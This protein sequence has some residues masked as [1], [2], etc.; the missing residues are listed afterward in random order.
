MMMPQ[1]FLINTYRKMFIKGPNYLESLLASR[2]LWP[3]IS[4]SFTLL[5]LELKYFYGN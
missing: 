4:F 3:D 2:L 5:V 1:M